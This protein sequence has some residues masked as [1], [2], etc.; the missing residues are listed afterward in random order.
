MSVILV[1]VTGDHIATSPPPTTSNGWAAPVEAA[2]SDVFGQSVDVDGGDGFG[3]VAAIGQGA[4]TLVID[5][6]DDASDWL[7]RRWEGE[8]PGAPLAF[9]IE[10][11]RWIEVLFGPRELLTLREAAEMMGIKAATLRQEILAEVDHGG[12]PKARRL[13]AVK[14]GRDWFLSR[15]A[16]AAEIESQA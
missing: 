3:C 15:A 9:E 14:R 12:S 4:W 16:V 7:N 5:L 1:E 13:G 2:L 10:V 8:G 11:P 6:P